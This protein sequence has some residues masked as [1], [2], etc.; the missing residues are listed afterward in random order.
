MARS[1]IEAEYKA[2]ANASSELIWINSLLRELHISLPALI[3]WCHNIGATYLSANPVFH[4]RMKHIEVDFH[5]IREQVT[6]RQLHVCVI[7][8]QDQIAD[9][10]TKALPRQRFLLL[11]SK[12]NVLPA[13]HLWGGVKERT[14]DRQSF[15]HDETVII[16]STVTTILLARI[17]VLIPS[18]EISTS[19]NIDVYQYCPDIEYKIQFLCSSLFFL[20]DLTSCFSL[21]GREQ[22]SYRKNNHMPY[23]PQVIMRRKPKKVR[24]KLA[25]ISRSF[26]ICPERRRCTH[27]YSES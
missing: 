18:F 5:F 24:T 19:I 2:V 13:F 21:L 17:L 11:R 7:S 14:H 9:L 22:E 16:V 26:G 4:A 25:G 20:L 27:D 10:L 3:L 1:S 12:L 23:E 6:A 15:S 8:S